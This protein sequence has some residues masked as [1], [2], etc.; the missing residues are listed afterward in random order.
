MI[1]T[2]NEAETGI[3]AEVPSDVEGLLPWYA[4]GTLR[5]DETRR[6]EAALARDPEL[7]RHY[8][9]VREELAETIGLNE[10][11]GAPSARAFDTLFAK[12]DAEPARKT[13][14]SFN[15]G[16]RLSSFLAGLSPRTLSLA[17]GV[18]VLA[19]LLQAGF[20]ASVLVR[21]TAPRHYVT[22]SA[23]STNPGVGAFALIRFAPQASQ[24]DVTKFL[25]DNALSIVAG[26]ADN[27]FYRV[28]LSASTLPQADYVTVIQKLR[29]D[30]VV[31]FIAATE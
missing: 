17:G 15:L 19:I 29:T 3:N 6:V 22:A 2:E 1:K 11:L 24:D 30:K 27:G 12:I 26:P 5:P 8:A 31:G 9:L 7:A 16:A 4:A 10:T 13:S 21:G 23:P 25:K 28:R 20:I 14:P 18:A